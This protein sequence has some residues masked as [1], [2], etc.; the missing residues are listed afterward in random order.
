MAA[1]LRLFTRLTRRGIVLLAVGVVAYVLVEAISFVQTY[2][3]EASRMRLS[4][5]GDQP[6]VRMLQGIPHAVETV[7]G[8]VVWDGGWFLQAII[9]VWA[10]LT[11]SRLLRGEEDSGRAEFPLAGPVSG[12][13][14]TAS[15]LLTVT[16]GCLVAGLAVFVTIVVPSEDVLG[17]T[18]FA[19]GVAGFGIVM[20]S[21]T[22]VASQVVGVRRQAAAIGAAFLGIA[23][24]LRMV[25]NSS[26]GRS[27]V[28]WLSVFGW[29]DRLRPFGDNNVGVLGVYLVVAG[30]LLAGAFALRA[31]R[32]LGAAVLVRDGDIRSRPLLLKSP[33]RFAWRLTWG[34]L[35]GWGVG[36]AAYSFIIGSLVKAMGEVLADDPAYEQYLELLGM[37]KEDI[38]LGMVAVMAVV[39]GLI[40]SLY[41]A[42]RIG[43]VRNEEDAERAE[44]LLTRPLTRGRWLGGHLVLAV[45]S[46]VLL[47][48][49]AGTAT[50]VGAAVTGAEVSLL[51]TIDAG[52]NLLPVILLFGGLAVAM[53]GLAPRLTIGVPVG[54][55]VV[56]YVLSF[57]GP[58]LDLPG[59]V[60][61][62]SP[63]YHVALVPVNDFALTQ[64]LVM[65]GLALAA[66]AVG[67]VAFNRRDFVGA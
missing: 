7:G 53:F 48:L 10:I 12:L 26:D 50:W 27:W 20:A 32:D 64:G 62:I 34:T 6:A 36:V 11:T 57:V 35:V 5:F 49:L 39:S 22:A 37:T 60:V 44:H 63:F 56:A 61:G 15:A 13:Q 58:A 3:D 23:F 24:V 21:A 47:V 2:P 31:R 19:L 17:A 38:S 40:I 67:W 41:A 16:A 45:I 52:A 1:V 25:A 29:M 66:T 46:A 42:W 18:L 30:A 55:V 54:A 9:G 8:F 4:E 43:A 51:D 14:V 33:I 65:V 59:W 28:S